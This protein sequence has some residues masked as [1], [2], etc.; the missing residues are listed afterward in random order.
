MLDIFHSH[1]R[2]LL[3]LTISVPAALVL[4]MVIDLIFPKPRPG[5]TFGRTLMLLLLQLLVAGMFVWGLVVI[6]QR[7]SLFQQ[8]HAEGMVSFVFFTSVFFL[9][10]A[11]LSA[12][13]NLFYKHLEEMRRKSKK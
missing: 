3:E 7:F 9:S 13:V 10:Q 1:L 4:G 2:L 11:Q 8:D 6:V 5:E 12:R